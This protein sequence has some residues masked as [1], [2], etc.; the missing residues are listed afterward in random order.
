MDCSVRRA[1]DE[2]GNVTALT[3][4]LFAQIHEPDDIGLRFALAFPFRSRPTAIGMSRMKTTDLTLDVGTLMSGEQINHYGNGTFGN[5]Y[6]LDSLPSSVPP[7]AAATGSPS[8]RNGSSIGLPSRVAQASLRDSSSD[9]DHRS[10][11]EPKYPMDAHLD[12]TRSQPAPSYQSGTH[13]ENLSLFPSDSASQPQ[14]GNVT[15]PPPEATSGAPDLGGSPL[16]FH[17][18]DEFLGDPAVPDRDSPAFPYSSLSQM[19]EQ[20]FLPCSATP[21]SQDFLIRCSNEALEYFW[22]NPEHLNLIRGAWAGSHTPPFAPEE[23]RSAIDVE[24]GAR[25]AAAETDALLG[26]TGLGSTFCGTL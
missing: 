24:R 11:S 22:N 1:H 25:Q 10:A 15:F 12:L 9:A 17:L 16:G 20:F 18:I 26:S 14:L 6:F 7:S 19:F 23:I 13:L 21:Q 2:I 8:A 4:R 3:T 5:S